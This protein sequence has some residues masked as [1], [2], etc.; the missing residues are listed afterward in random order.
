M[1]KAVNLR[2]T[3]AGAFA[4]RFG[5]EER[6]EYLAQ[7]VGSDAGAGIRNRDRDKFAGVGFVAERRRYRRRP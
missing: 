4:D 5:R 6:V 3:Q 1:G 2:K 7:N